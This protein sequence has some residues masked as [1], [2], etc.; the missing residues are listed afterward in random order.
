MFIIITICYKSTGTLP[1]VMGELI[2]G[3]YL[4]I[5]LWGKQGHHFFLTHNTAYWGNKSGGKLWIM[6]NIIHNQ[7]ICSAGGK[8][9][10]KSNFS[11]SWHEKHSVPTFT[12][13]LVLATLKFWQS[14]QGL[15]CVR[16]WSTQYQ[17]RLEEERIIQFWD[18]E[19]HYYIWTV[20][21]EQF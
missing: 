10:K 7:L 9:R 3:W 13:T 8:N 17:N 16:N 15:P 14:W 21:S 6:Y 11:T 20:N 1:D 12:Y 19:E 5:S 2:T 18:R 4:Q